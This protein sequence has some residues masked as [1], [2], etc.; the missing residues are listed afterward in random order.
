MRARRDLDVQFEKQTGD[1]RSEGTWRGD[2]NA[3]DMSNVGR[4]GERLKRRAVVGR[5]EGV[6]IGESLLEIHATRTWR[7]KLEFRLQQRKSNGS[8]F[9]REE[10]EKE[11]G[12]KRM[13]MMTTESR[14]GWVEGVRRG[15]GTNERTDWA[16]ATS[17]E[18][19]DPPADQPT[20]SIA[21]AS[22]LIGLEPPLGNFAPTSPD[23]HHPRHVLVPVRSPV[24]ELPVAASLT[25]P[26]VSSQRANR[27]VSRP[28][29]RCLQRKSRR[30]SLVTRAVALTTGITTTHS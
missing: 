11:K 16:G 13:T 20:A 19:P 30:N 26:A 1:V 14:D 10:K 2:G 4:G 7:T 8:A 18:A 23:R 12:E 29:A 5:N 15:E 24:D 27:K 3:R 25:S 22:R 28:R 9:S 21:A 17:V 6:W